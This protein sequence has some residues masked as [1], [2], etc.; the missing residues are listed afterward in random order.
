[1][2]YMR[3]F[4]DLKEQRQLHHEP[5]CQK[6]IK[7]GDKEL[8]RVV[9][10]GQDPTQL[11]LLFVRT[12]TGRFRSSRSAWDRASLGPGVVVVMLSMRSYPARLF[13]VLTKAG[14]S[15]NAFAMLKSNVPAVF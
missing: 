7:E 14:R 13:S 15:L 11:S 5:V 3:G 2:N 12:K 6:N 9:I 10:P 1:M 4:T 8:W